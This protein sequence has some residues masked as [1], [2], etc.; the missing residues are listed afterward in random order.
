M[1]FRDV[2]GE[3]A[4][5]KQALTWRRESRV[6]VA[7]PRT[8]GCLCQA[9]I[10]GRTAMILLKL[11]LVPVLRWWRRASPSSRKEWHTSAAGSL[12]Y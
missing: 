3:E 6:A 4:G 10:D 2:R 11:W 5:A 1:L 9:I 8:R 7:R 12:R